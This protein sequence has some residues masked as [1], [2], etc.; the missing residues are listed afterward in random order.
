MN[1]LQSF[2]KIYNSFIFNLKYNVHNME[3]IIKPDIY[4]KLSP[5]KDFYQKNTIK[6]LI[7]KLF[8]RQ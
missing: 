7:I 2:K 1:L 4:L 3:N 6:S 5:L 8:S